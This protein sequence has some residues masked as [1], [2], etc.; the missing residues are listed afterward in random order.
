MVETEGDRMKHFLTQC[1]APHEPAALL[2]VSFIALLAALSNSDILGKILRATQA[3]QESIC[4]LHTVMSVNKS[5]LAAARE[6]LADVQWLSPF[7]KSAEKFLRRDPLLSSRNGPVFYSF[8]KITG[9]LL[10]ISMYRSHPGVQEAACYVLGKLA[11]IKYNKATI[12]GAGGIRMV[13]DAM[14]IHKED[15]SVQVAGCE[16]LGKIAAKSD[17]NKKTIVSAGGIGMVVSAMTA[18]PWD[19]NM[20]IMGLIVLCRLA[21]IDGIITEMTSAGAI[22]VVVA[23]MVA[24][25]DNKQFQE[26]GCRMLYK[27][28]ENTTDYTAIVSA[29]GINV[30]ISAMNAHMGSEDV[31]FLGCNALLELAQDD[32][33]RKAIVGAGG[34]SVVLAFM[35]VSVYKGDTG[36][37]RSLLEQGCVLLER[38]GRS[39]MSLQKRIKNEGGTVV[40][41]AA[42]N[43]LNARDVEYT[44]SVNAL[45][46]RD[47][48]NKRAVMATDYWTFAQVRR[49]ADYFKYARAGRELLEKMARV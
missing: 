20:Q 14:T 37:Q 42:V 34:I 46:A 39:D 48:Q 40:L 10:G 35:R 6:V 8:R 24:H 21:F 22:T 2:P 27:L 3:G 4:V 19:K 7:L 38:I 12:A 9:L 29:G 43:A 28:L 16:A 49:A 31:E 5:W 45:N 18:Y 26:E 47:R 41:E 32:N 44:R 25:M 23:V 13:V 1:Q 17:D 30:I 15:V 11:H 36:L 33:T